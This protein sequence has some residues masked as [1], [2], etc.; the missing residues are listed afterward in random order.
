[1]QEKE[2]HE[3][4]SP[5]EI[6]QKGKKQSIPWPPGKWRLGVPSKKGRY[7]FLRFASKGKPF[8]KV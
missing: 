7:L 8:D 3:M 1:M 5:E 4:L 2:T 6:S